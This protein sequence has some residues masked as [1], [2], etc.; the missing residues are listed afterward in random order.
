MGYAAQ[1]ARVYRINLGPDKRL[2]QGSGP[3][4]RGIK[5]DV[6]IVIIRS[7]KAVFC[8]YCQIYILMSNGYMAGFAADQDVNEIYRVDLL[9]V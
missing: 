9:E 5:R 7:M 8:G 1:I 3:R 6:C 4:I 2:I